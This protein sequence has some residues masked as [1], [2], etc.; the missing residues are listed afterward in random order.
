MS[1]GGLGGFVEDY[2]HLAYVLGFGIE[3]AKNVAALTKNIVHF[4]RYPNEIPISAAYHIPKM[5]F[6]STTSVTFWGA[7]KIYHAG[8]KFAEW[9]GVVPSKE[10]SLEGMPLESSKL[11]ILFKKIAAEANKLSDEATS[12]VTKK[13]VKQLTDEFA[14][15]ES[16]FKAIDLLGPALFLG[17]CSN[18]ALV[19][20]SSA[21][22][23]AKLLLLN[24]RIV[25]TAYQSPSLT[26]NTV[27]I[28]EKTQ[29]YT[30]GRLLKDTVIESVFTALWSTGA[31]FTYEGIYKAVLEASNNNSIQASFVAN[32]LLTAGIAV[33]IL[34]GWIEEALYMLPE[35][36]HKNSKIA[37]HLVY[38]ES[39][40][41][42]PDRNIIDKAVTLTNEQKLDFLEQIRQ[43]PTGN[44]SVDNQGG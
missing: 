26:S 9:F 5:A 38:S 22:H 19:N 12:W 16:C 24:K 8:S 4:Y 36:Q 37:P 34:Y 41:E 35:T 7:E 14:A 3:T 13:S 23:H 17:F 33:P 11:E 39:S 31:Y 15:D 32:T 42:N 28:V 29:R 10:I 30:T 18:K 6:E 2:N 25:S 21:A 27:A 20:L 1:I 44:R 43:Y 40:D